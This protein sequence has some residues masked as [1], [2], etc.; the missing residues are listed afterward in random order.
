MGAGIIDGLLIRMSIWPSAMSTR[1]HDLNLLRIATTC[2]LQAAMATFLIT[3]NSNVN[4]LGNNPAHWTEASARVP[5]CESES[6]AFMANRNESEG[7]ICRLV[8]IETQ[9]PT[10]R[11]CA[12]ECV[13][14]WASRSWATTQLRYPIFRAALHE[15]ESPTTT[16]HQSNPLAEVNPTRL[17]IQEICCIAHTLPAIRT[18]SPYW[19][20]TIYKSHIHLS[21]KK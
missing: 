11:F 15:S 12:T 16:T 9:R 2:S 20:R 6:L 14:Y 7:F 10:D 1:S 8:F 19:T 21:V 5:E 13:S 17:N 18:Q 3:K 4:S